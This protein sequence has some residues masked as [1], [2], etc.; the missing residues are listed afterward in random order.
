MR[1]THLNRSRRW[2]PDLL[3]DPERM[4]SRVEAV[5]DEDP[6]TPEDVVVEGTF[7]AV[8][9]EALAALPPRFQ[10]VVRLVD[11]EA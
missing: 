6:R 8:V 1:N 4:R 5:P 10:L 7:D 3:R 2:R 11:V 9:A